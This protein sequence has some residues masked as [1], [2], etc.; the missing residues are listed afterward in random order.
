MEK[1]I[2]DDVPIFTR[3]FRNK[4]VVVLPPCFSRLFRVKSACACEFANMSSKYMLV[5]CHLCV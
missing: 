2:V 4:S 1:L 3:N 5:T